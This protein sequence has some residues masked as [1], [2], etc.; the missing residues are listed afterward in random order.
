MKEQRGRSIYLSACLVIGLLTVECAHHFTAMQTKEIVRE[1]QDA[2]VQIVFLGAIQDPQSGQSRDT[3]L[4]GTGFIISDDGYV[5]TAEHVIGDG[6]VDS[7]DSEGKMLKVRDIKVIIRDGRTLDA[8]LPKPYPPGFGHDIGILKISKGHGLSYLEIP[9]QDSLELG[10]PLVVLGHPGVEPNLTVTEGI[11]NNFNPQR[12]QLR[13]SAM[14][15][16]GISG[17]PVLNS[18][19]EAIGI[20]RLSKVGLFNVAANLAMHREKILEYIEQDRNR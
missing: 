6:K 9:K 3:T 15:T 17:S 18:N 4:I 14:I 19:G 16:P 13:V 12:T 8:E 10:Q 5:L 1:S 11:I 2:V 20:A 7:I